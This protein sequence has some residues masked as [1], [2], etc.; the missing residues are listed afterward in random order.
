MLVDVDQRG[1]SVTDI[2]LILCYRPYVSGLDRRAEDDT[3]AQTLGVGPVAVGHHT[4]VVGVADAEAKDVL[5]HHVPHRR[6]HRRTKGTV[7]ARRL[8]LRLRLLYSVV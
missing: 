6:V 8:R 7:V 1:D 4:E 5:V 2:C 3:P